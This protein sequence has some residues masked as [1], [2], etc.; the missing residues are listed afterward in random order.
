MNENLENLS[1][2]IE[3]FS[4]SPA[5]HHAA[6]QSMEKVLDVAKETVV[7]VLDFDDDGSIADTL[8]DLLEGIL[9]FF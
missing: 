5:I 4:H 6:H 2:A 8:P 7:E 1:E 3:H 9:N